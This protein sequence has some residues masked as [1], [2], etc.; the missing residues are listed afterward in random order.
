LTELLAQWRGDRGRSTFIFRPSGSDLEVLASFAPMGRDAAHAV[1]VFLDDAASTRQR[2]QQ[3]K[4]ASLGRLTASIAHEIR[5]PLSAIR[6]AGQLLTETPTLSSGD[7]RLTGIIEDNCQRMNAIVENVLMLSRR[8][9]AVIENFTLAPWLER[10]VMD[11]CRETGLPQD[12]I[13]ATVT[14]ADLVIR[15][16]STQLH[17]VLR[18]LCENGVR[19]GGPEPLL[20]IKVGLIEDTGRPF[21]EVIDSGTGID[22]EVAEQLFEPFFTTVAEGTGL[23]LYIARELCEINRASLSLLRHEGQGT[24]FRIIFSDPRR[25]G[26]LS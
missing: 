26:A 3:L 7:L 18:N 2:A 10:F 22:E 16:D 14:P 17:Q 21:M 11:F 6:H 12:Q 1:T 9:E 23:G 20:K 24:H 13:Q 19:H 15:M 25:Q 5:N 8:R 4:L